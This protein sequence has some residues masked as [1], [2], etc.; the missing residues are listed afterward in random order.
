MKFFLVKGT[1]RNRQQRTRYNKVEGGIYVA[2][3]V[4][5]SCA[6]WN[7]KIID[8]SAIDGTNITGTNGDIEHLR[9]YIGKRK[10][11]KSDTAYWITDRT[12][13]EFLPLSDNTY[14]QYF[15]IITHQGSSRLRDYSTSNPVG[16]VLNADT[17]TL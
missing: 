5:N 12:P 8:D 15:S 4:S 7:S 1:L 2:S 16:V 9:N 6:A 17:K 10:T 11:L 3:S 14:T 13:F